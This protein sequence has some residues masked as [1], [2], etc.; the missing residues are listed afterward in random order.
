MYLTNEM[1]TDIESK[2]PHMKRDCDKV[3]SAKGPI[4]DVLEKTVCMTLLNIE[5]RSLKTNEVYGLAQ[6]L[7]I[8]NEVK[9]V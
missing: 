7:S 9:V 2:Y 5:A 8:V 1:I 6:S 3:R 4:R